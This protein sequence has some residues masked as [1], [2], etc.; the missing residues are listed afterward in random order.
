MAFTSLDKALTDRIV[1]LVMNHAVDH[2]AASTLDGAFPNTAQG[3]HDKRKHDALC[4]DAADLKSLQAR[5]IKEVGDATVMP[6]AK[7]TE[8]VQEAKP[9]AYA[10]TVLTQNPGPT[11][12]VAD[13]VPP[14]LT[15]DPY[16]PIVITDREHPLGSAPGPEQ[17]LDSA[18]YPRQL[19][20]VE[21][22]IDIKN[23]GAVVLTPPEEKI[24]DAAE[25]MFN[26]N[27]LA[28]VGTAE[29]KF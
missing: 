26:G 23:V 25:V 28:V 10:G 7:K 14:V 9:L 6:R 17:E 2:K 16:S 1:R 11:V 12:V 20:S 3:R 22:P 13:L 8:Q 5:M 21:P 15:N 24:L 18:A 19:T 4:R 29:E 27:S